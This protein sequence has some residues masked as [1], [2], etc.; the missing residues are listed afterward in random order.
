MTGLNAPNKMCSSLS[1]SYFYI[2]CQV[3]INSVQIYI[4]PTL[5]LSTVSEPAA[6]KT[7]IS[8]NTLRKGHLNCLNARSRGLTFRHRASCI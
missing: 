7:L 4:R 3:V 1:L 2:K 8:L 6:L 5:D